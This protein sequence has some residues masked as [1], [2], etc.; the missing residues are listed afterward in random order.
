[1]HTFVVVCGVV[2]D[3]PFPKHSLSDD[4]YVCTYLHDNFLYIGR[5][6]R[7]LH[8]PIPT[9]LSRT[10]HDLHA[11]RVATVRSGSLV[12][13]ESGHFFLIIISEFR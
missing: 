4:A 9:T 6:F 7:A 13:I 2:L 11:V 8:G 3:V 5:P 10:V 12:S 1:M